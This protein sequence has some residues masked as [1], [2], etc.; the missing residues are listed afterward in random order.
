MVS[1]N[2]KSGGPALPVGQLTAE[3]EAAVEESMKVYLKPVNYYTILQD[4][5]KDKVNYFFCM[6]FH[7]YRIFIFLGMIDLLTEFMVPN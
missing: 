4:R 1:C 3:E 5:D 6:L 7:L 2:R